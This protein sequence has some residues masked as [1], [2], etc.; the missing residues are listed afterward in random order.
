MPNRGVSQHEPPTGRSSAC[1]LTVRF[2]TD[3]IR[4]ALGNGPTRP[5]GMV[6]LGPPIDTRQLTVDTF[7]LG[8]SLT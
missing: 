8:A 5:G 2:G 7:V 4:T 1:E 3:I 6:V